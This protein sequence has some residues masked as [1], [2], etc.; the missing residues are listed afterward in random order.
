MSTVSSKRKTRRNAQGECS[1]S[2]TDDLPVEINSISDKDFHEITN[3]V[4]RKS[5][6]KGLKDQSDAQQEMLKML[7]PI[8]KPKTRLKRRR[9]MLKGNPFCTAKWCLGISFVLQT[10]KKL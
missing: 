6:A 5:L 3:K 4:E 10:I 2:V 7:S 9:L 8:Q 1:G